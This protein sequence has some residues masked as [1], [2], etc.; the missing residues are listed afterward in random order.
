M[1]GLGIFLVALAMAVGLVGTVLPL[2]PGSVLIWGAGLVYGLVAGFGGPGGWLFGLMTLVLIVGTVAE[3]VLPT[4]G[5]AE[6]GASTQTLVVGAIF[7]VIGFFVI[8]VVG[9]PL[10]AVLGVLLA[11]RQRTGNWENAWYRTR[12]V[13][14]GFGLGV[15]AEFTA[16]LLMILLWIGWVISS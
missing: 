1:S 9:L 10:G 13:L 5:G 15:L 8:P 11:E 6:R 2:L 3:Y 14:R 12:G 16:G 7:G 4:R